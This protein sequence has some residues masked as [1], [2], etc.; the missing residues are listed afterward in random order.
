METNLTEKELNQ[1]ALGYNWM[2]DMSYEDFIR[3]NPEL[4]Y[5]KS[6]ELFEDIDKRYIQYVYENDID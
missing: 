4:S 2:P 3:L 1:I 5:D 6:Y